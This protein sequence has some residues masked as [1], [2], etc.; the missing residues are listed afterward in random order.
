MT[1]P[2]E[3]TAANGT[4]RLRMVR[5]VGC[6]LRRRGTREFRPRAIEQET[7]VAMRYE[8]LSCLLVKGVDLLALDELMATCCQRMVETRGKRTL[9]D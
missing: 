7:V 3:T 2:A 4:R 5:V 1:I 6:R 8:V 9:T